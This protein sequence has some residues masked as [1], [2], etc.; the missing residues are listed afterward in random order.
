MFDATLPGRSLLLLTECV[1]LLCAAAMSASRTTTS[2]GIAYV[3]RPPHGKDGFMRGGRFKKAS[4]MNFCM[5]VSQQV[6][7]VMQARLSMAPVIN[8]R[9]AWYKGLHWGQACNAASVHALA[10]KA[11]CLSLE[12]RL[13]S[14]DQQCISI[15]TPGHRCL[16]ICCTLHNQIE[17]ELPA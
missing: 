6:S 15:A 7:Q 12:L 1:T 2:T 9:R 5:T 10:S 16:L 4:N 14:S 3:A 8:M 13:S 11:I 17:Q